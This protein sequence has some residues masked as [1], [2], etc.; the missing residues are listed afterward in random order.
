MSLQPMSQDQSEVSSNSI[1]NFACQKNKRADIWIL[2]LEG[3]NILFIQRVYEQLI[4]DNHILS[5]I[6][7]I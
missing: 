1:I 2:G 6:L 5:F 4:N 3:E 7:F